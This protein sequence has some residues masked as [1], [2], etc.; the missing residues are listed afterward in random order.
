MTAATGP[1]KETPLGGR[2]RFH[3]ICHRVA[4]QRCCLWIVSTIGHRLWL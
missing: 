4:F 3:T 1:D 2:L